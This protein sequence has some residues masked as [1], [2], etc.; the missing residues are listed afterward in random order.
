M[1]DAVPTWRECCADRTEMLARALSVLMRIVDVTSLARE[2]ERLSASIGITNKLLETYFMGAPL[3]QQPIRTDVVYTPATL[4]TRHVALTRRYAND[5]DRWLEPCCGGGV[6]YDRLPEPKDWCELDK[7]R[8]FFQF[9]GECDVLITNPPY[10]LMDAFLVKCV[11]LRPRVISLN[12]SAGGFR[13]G[14]GQVTETRMDFMRANG[15]GL[16][17]LL[18]AEVKGWMNRVLCSVFV[19]GADWENCRVEYDITPHIAPDM[20]LLDP[21]LAPV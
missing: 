10:S 16:V 13:G 21:L 20:M 1:S 9:H 12:C 7:G 19:L 3:K 5:G 2:H 14:F 8:D 6:Y 18:F 4:A 11:S 15:Y 17:A